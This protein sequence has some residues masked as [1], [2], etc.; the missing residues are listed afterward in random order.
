MAI[1]PGPRKIMPAMLTLKRV[2]DGL[3]DADELEQASYGP[4]ALCRARC[5]MPSARC[6]MPDA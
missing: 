6:P 4:R 2:I 3:T 5:P 1:G